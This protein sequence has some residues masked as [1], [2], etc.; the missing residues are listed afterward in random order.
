VKIGLLDVD[1]HNFPNLALMKISAWHK[2]QGDQV[3]M[4]FPMNHYDKVY[5]SKVFDFSPDFETCIKADEV[6]R[7]GRAYDKKV[8]LL[9]EIES[10]YP[11]YGL[12]GIADT[13]YGY[14]VRG[15]PWGCGFCDVQNIEGKIAYKVAD[16]NQFWNGQSEIK[17][18]DPNTLAYSGHMELLEQLANSGAWVDFTQGVD[19]WM[20]TLENVEMLSRIKVKMI[21]FAWDRVEDT[22]PYM[23]WHFKKRTNMEYQKL[24]VYVLTNYDTTQEQDLYRVYKLK[25][26]GYDPYIMIFNKS[27]FVTDKHRLKPI[28]QLLEK[29][30][31]EQIE[32]FKK[33]WQ[34]QRWVNNKRIF[35]SGQ[36]ETFEDYLRGVTK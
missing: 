18:L 36:A 7:G 27:E 31:I 17:L 2:S 21:H 9:P 3:E 5:M 13:A 34:L 33:T 6:V 1:G 11:D 35:R 32:H 29:F 15:C 26:M 22:T 8:K 23:L 12:Y 28:K 30:S 10:T 14:L 24:K 19:A 16:L 25:D 4:V 20:L